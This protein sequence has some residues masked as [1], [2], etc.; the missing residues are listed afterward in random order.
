VRQARRQQPSSVSE[1]PLLHD[2]LSEADYSHYRRQRTT[3]RVSSISEPDYYLNNSLSEG[4]YGMPA[5]L[6]H[7]RTQGSSLRGGP[8]PMMMQRIV[9]VNRSAA[10]D[11]KPERLHDSFS[12]VEYPSSR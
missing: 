7:K 10:Q 3:P 2:S 12:H 8:K 6:Q 5:V 9:V 4:T 1:P 11:D